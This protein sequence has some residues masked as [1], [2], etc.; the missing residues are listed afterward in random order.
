MAVKKQRGGYKITFP[1]VAIDVHTSGKDLAGIG[2]VRIAGRLMRSAEEMI[3]PA[4]VTP[5][6]L[7]I[8]RYEL[9]RVIKGKT[10][11]TLRT[12]PVWRTVP[13]MEWT[14][15]AMHALTP[16][17]PWSGGIASPKSARLDITLKPVKRKIDG[18]PYTGV[19][20]GFSYRCKGQRIYHGPSGNSTATS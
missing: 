1:D 19:E 7:L 15:H 20:Y 12:R 10:S 16:T 14:E 3:L 2:K 5:D 11:V 17:D 8:H 13:K 4:I 9:V 18:R 6:G